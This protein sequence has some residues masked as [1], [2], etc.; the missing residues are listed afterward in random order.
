MTTY[1]RIYVIVNVVDDGQQQATVETEQ[2]AERT[3]ATRREAW[4]VLQDMLQSARD[5][6]FG[7][8]EAPWCP[9][10]GEAWILSSLP[11]GGGTRRV[12]ALEAEVAQA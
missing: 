1:L 8:A 4:A 5:R 6:G 7:V 2:Q 12:V 11:G 3:F 10:Q 9:P